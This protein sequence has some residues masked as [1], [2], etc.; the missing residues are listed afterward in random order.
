[1]EGLQIW[2]NT[3]LSGEAQEINN[4]QLTAEWSRWEKGGGKG[5][6][7]GVKQ[8]GR[9]FTLEVLLCQ[10]LPIQ[11]SVTQVNGMTFILLEKGTE[12]QSVP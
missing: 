12:V 5:E 10:T 6:D 3:T 4:A 9:N 11:P 1:M 7:V 2:V 8:E